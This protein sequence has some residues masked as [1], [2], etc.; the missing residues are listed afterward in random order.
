VRKKFKGKFTPITQ[1]IGDDATAVLGYARP[2]SGLKITPEQNQ[3]TRKVVPSKLTKWVLCVCHAATLFLIMF[4]KSIWIGFIGV[5]LFVASASAAGPGLQGIVKDVKGHPIQGADI[6]IEATKTGGLLTTVKTNVNGRYSLEGLAA[7]NYRVTLVVNGAVKASIN[8]TTL[9]PGE[10]TQ[11]NFELKQ[12]RAYVT[13]TKGKHRVW[14]PA[15]TGSRLPGRWVEVDDSGG[16]SAAN[17][18]ANHIVRVSGEELAREVH[19]FNPAIA[20]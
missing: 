9:D 19:N 20:P 18:T 6:R 14:V 11:L 3:I 7:G 2:F 5:M 13:V 1:A 17:A 8:N 15:F 4:I 12:T 16:W 10:S